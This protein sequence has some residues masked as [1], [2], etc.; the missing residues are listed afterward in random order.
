MNLNQIT[1][2]ATDL[3][4]SIPFYQCLGLK[5][6]VDS[7]P[8][9]ARFECPEGDTTLSLHQVEI[10]Q[11]SSTTAVYFECEDLDSKVKAL[12]KKAIVFDQDPVD[13]RWLW[14]EAWLKDP[15]DNPICLF[16]GGRNR[17]YPPWRIDSDQ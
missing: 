11:G 15:D 16:W 6:I 10:S 4:V 12:K 3:A 8:R 7:Q 17:K 5:L 1:I 9:Y 13:Q 2:A 14:R